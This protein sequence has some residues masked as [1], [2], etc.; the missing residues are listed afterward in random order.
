MSYEQNVQKVC[1]PANADL[2]STGQFRFGVINASGKI[3]LATAG[4]RVDGVVMNNP[5][6]DQAVEF[7]VGGIIMVE[8][9]GNVTAGDSVE[10][11]SNGV[12][13]TLSG[14]TYSAGVALQTGI[15]G[16]I[17]PILFH[18]VGAVS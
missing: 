8:Y 16:D 12:A 14:A 2:S 17:R 9:G 1:L 13:V 7:G 15:S 6:E 5:D 18:P 11:G 3:A 4:E 10:A